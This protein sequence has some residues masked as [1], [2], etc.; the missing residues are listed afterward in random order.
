M[1][2][3]CAGDQLG[4]ARSGIMPSAAV[5]TALMLLMSPATRVR[6]PT[7]NWDFERIDGH[8]RQGQVGAGLEEF[9]P[10]AAV[11]EEIR[12]RYPD[13]APVSAPPPGECVRFAKA[14]SPVRAAGGRE[15]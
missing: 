5:A 4:G 10:R 3:A 9:P 12:K 14:K 15:H 6:R 7:T 1:L 13:A 2:G 8:I 11:V